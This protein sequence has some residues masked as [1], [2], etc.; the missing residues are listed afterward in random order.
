MSGKKKLITIGEQTK[1]ISQWSRA[2]GVSER[3]ISYRLKHGVSG[4]ELVAPERSS[5]SKKV[6]SRVPFVDMTGQRFDRLEVES[7]AGTRGRDNYRL[8]NC[9]CDCGNPTVVATRD[10]RRGNVKSCG[11]LSREGTVASGVN[12][13]AVG[14]SSLNQLYGNY[15]RSAASRGHLFEL[16]KGEFYQLTSSPCFYCGTEPSQPGPCVAGTHGRYT[17]N[18]IDRVDNDLGYTVFNVRPCCKVCN[19]AKGVLTEAQFFAWAAKVYDRLWVILEERG[20]FVGI[21]DPD[22][23]VDL[24]LPEQTY[25]V[26]QWRKPT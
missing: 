7:F 19:Y 6:W 23:V 2:T 11:C 8:W 1:S 17:Y 26:T 9:R 13:L 3:K 10:L 18:G 25:D 5:I 16:T 4:P 22:E 24:P 20:Q 12:R 15:R 21:E 14:E